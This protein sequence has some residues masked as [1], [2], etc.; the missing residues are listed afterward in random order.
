MA[1]TSTDN[2]PGR[3]VMRSFGLLHSEDEEKL[4]RLLSRC[5]RHLDLLAPSTAAQAILVRNPFAS[6]P[7]GGLGSNGPTA[8]GP[9]HL[10]GRPYNEKTPHPAKRSSWHRLQHTHHHQAAPQLACLRTRL[11]RKA[12][13]PGPC[14][15][16]RH[17]SMTQLTS[18]FPNLSR[19]ID[20][21]SSLI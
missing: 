4:A 21:Q 9:A 15:T 17:F 8:A 20:V 5:L 13:Q 19:L 3:Q 2:V 14:F 18:A 16:R 10:G 7:G 6:N 11:T 12:S 1:G